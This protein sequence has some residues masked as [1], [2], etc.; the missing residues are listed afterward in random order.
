MARISDTTNKKLDQLSKST[1]K[2]KQALLE[3]AVQQLVRNYF[4][5]QANKAYKD[6]RQDKT[7]WQKEL[8]ERDL[9]DSTLYDGLD[10]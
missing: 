5:H 10:F 7:A 9:W 6:L 1:G 8:A 2:S 3:E 4:L